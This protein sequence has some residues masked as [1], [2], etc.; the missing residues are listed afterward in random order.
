MGV[1]IAFSHFLTMFR[2]FKLI[3]NPPVAAAQSQPSPPPPPPLQSQ[4]SNTTGS[5]NPYFVDDSC[6]SAALQSN[7]WKTYLAIGPGG[8]VIQSNTL[9]ANAVF[10][11]IFE[12]DGRI[13]F[14]TK[15]NTYISAGSKAEQ[16]LVKTMPN[17]QDAERF[18]IEGDSADAV[19]LNSF[20]RG[21]Y[22]SAR[23]AG[24][25]VPVKLMPWHR[26][27]E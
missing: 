26:P 27:W 12:D 16:F 10:T 4:E 21:N 17:D 20:W 18:C 7:Q 6:K 2:Y 14:H 22:V 8:T 1:S 23:A 3:C 5:S 9:D 25:P 11:L 19:A 24:E 15:N 13:A